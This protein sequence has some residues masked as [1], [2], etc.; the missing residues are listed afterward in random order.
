MKKVKNRG[1][2]MKLRKLLITGL[3]D[4]I[5]EELYN[6][7]KLLVQCEHTLNIAN[8]VIKIQNHGNALV[9]VLKAIKAIEN[10]LYKTKNKIDK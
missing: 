8:A 1:E 10:Y 9:D 5:K 6:C 3:K 7:R 2:K 4:P